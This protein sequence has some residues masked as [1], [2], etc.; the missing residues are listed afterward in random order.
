MARSTLHLRRRPAEPA[1]TPESS[2]STPDVV[3]PRP[4]TEGP[5]PD[6]EGSNATRSTPDPQAERHTVSGHPSG[7]GRPHNPYP[8]GNV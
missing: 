4:R 7:G 1:A 6:P 2:P 8:T 5:E 3:P